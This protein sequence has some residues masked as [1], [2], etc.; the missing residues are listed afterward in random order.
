MTAQPHQ[1]RPPGAGITAA[2]GGLL[3][4]LKVAA[5]VLDPSGRVA[6]WSAEA[7]ELFGYTAEEAMGLPAA[8]LM[9]APENRSLAIELFDRVRAGAIWA[10]VFPVRHKDGSERQVEFRNMSLLDRSGNVLAL[11]LAADVGT[12]RRVETDMALSDRLVEQSPVGVGVL[13]VDLRFTRVNGAL[14]EIAGLPPAALVGRTPGEVMPALG[15]RRMKSRLRQV[16]DTGTPVID[17]RVAGRTAADPETDRVWSVSHYRLDDSTGRVFGLAVSIMDVSERHRIAAE[18]IEARERLAVL[19]DASVRIGTTLDLQQT[20]RELVDV[21]VPR[22]ADL[23]A[24]DVLDAALG[25]TASAL[26]S[27]DGGSSFRALAVAS[28]YPTEAIQ[29]ADPVGEIAHYG[30][31]RA[32]TRTVR[33][34]RPIRLPRVDAAMVR[35]MSRD[36]HAAGALLD[37]GVHSYLATP[38]IARGEV[39]GTLSLY[40][41]VNP[42]PFDEQDESLSCELAAR[43]AVCIDNA[44]I[45]GRERETALTLQ[46]SLLPE[47]PVG[48]GALRTAVRYRPA[49]GA[50]EIGGD[51]FDVLPLVGDKVGLVVG[52]VM[53]S[54][55]RAAAIMGQLRIATR[56]LAGLDL[57][58]ADLL[59]H[60]DEIAAALSDSFATCVYA[61]CD[62]SRR[63]CEISS[64]G[65][66]PPIL[67]PPDGAAA[68]VDIPT[69]APLGVGGVPF[70]TVALDLAEGTLLAFYTDGLVERRDQA[71]DTGLQALRQLLTGTAGQPLEETCDVVLD[72]LFHGADDD[73]ALLLARF[74]GSPPAA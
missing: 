17:Q 42:R 22:L 4:L 43:A 48:H 41:T 27:S 56:T 60:L 33:E 68:F 66:L 52:D 35:H 19:V 62:L 2:P 70:S 58:P 73:V 47:E 45:Y 1:D 65:H 74:D 14:A 12:V 24:V 71:I 49:A 30:P 50:S 29:A 36:E 9:V 40:R 69:A 10:G 59:S 63:R 3:D 16:L 23:A 61:V 31:S 53:G 32:L 54:G 6:L 15:T 11:G 25:G 46:R 21:A 72:G 51:W 67:V 7:E 8:R 5:V 39:L 44:R 38:L 55:V 13:G 57:P 26:T 37:A 20:A 34:A 64:A 28:S 18:A